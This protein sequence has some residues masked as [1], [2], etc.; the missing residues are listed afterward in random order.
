MTTLIINDDGVATTITMIPM[1][2]LMMV[3][4]AM[5]TPGTDLKQ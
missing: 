3:S 5:A 4:V 2:M 1:M